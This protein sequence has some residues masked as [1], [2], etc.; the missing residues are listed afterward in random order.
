MKRPAV[1]LSRVLLKLLVLL[2]VVSLH[3]TMHELGHYAAAKACDVNVTELYIGSGPVLYQGRLSNGAEI[4]I[5][6]YP[7][8]GHVMHLG[9]ASSTIVRALISAAGML[10]TVLAVFLAYLLLFWRIPSGIPWHRSV[11]SAFQL[12]FLEWLLFPFR[13]LWSFLS[14][15]P[16]RLLERVWA[17]VLFLLGKEFRIGVATVSGGRLMVLACINTV[18]IL[19]GLSLLPALDF[20]SDC[21]ALA[22]MALMGLLGWTG[23]DVWVYL[24][25]F[26][27]SAIIISFLLFTIVLP[28]RVYRHVRKKMEENDKEDEEFGPDDDER[29]PDP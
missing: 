13:L 12:S 19:N 28:L 20:S 2:L 6:L 5:A 24:V 11:W 3:L 9:G 29:P 10:S 23:L 22:T 18:A 25:T 14:L 1:L 7:T 21:D 8:R 16:H 17:I 27:Y 15:R 26:L 4:R